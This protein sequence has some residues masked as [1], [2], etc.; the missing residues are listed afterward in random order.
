MCRI[1]LLHIN[2]I[3]LLDKSQQYAYQMVRTDSRE[4]KLDAFVRPSSLQ[5][6]I[7]PSNAQTDRDNQNSPT[8]MDTTIVPTGSKGS[9]ITCTLVI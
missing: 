8:E 3:I 6:A 2:N 7:Q 4:L 9:V 1:A 5:Q